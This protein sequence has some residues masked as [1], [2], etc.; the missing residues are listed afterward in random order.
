MERAKR[1]EERGE[2]FFCFRRF[3]VSSSLSLFLKMEKKT[4]K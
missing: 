2:H 4:L 1:G 3:F